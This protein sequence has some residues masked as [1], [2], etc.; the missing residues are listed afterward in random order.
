[1][2]SAVRTEKCVA[3]STV[4][5]NAGIDAQKNTRRPI[6]PQQSVAADVELR[7]GGNDVARQC[8]ASCPVAAD[9]EV[10]GSLLSR[11]GLQ[12]VRTACRKGAADRP[13]HCQISCDQSISCDMKPGCWRRGADAHIRVRCRSVHAA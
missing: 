2:L 10:S 11:G 6:K 4:F 13:A 1:M 9:V 7:S 5:I 12:V 8:S 3:G